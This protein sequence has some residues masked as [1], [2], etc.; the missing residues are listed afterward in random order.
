MCVCMWCFCCCLC[1]DLLS[2]YM[3]RISND[4]NCSGF[5]FL[6]VPIRFCSILLFDVIIFYNSGLSSYVADTQHKYEH[7]MKEEEHHH[8]IIIQLSIS[9]DSVICWT[10]NDKGE[11]QKQYSTI[12]KWRKSKWKIS[13]ELWRGEVC[14][15][16]AKRKITKLTCLLIKR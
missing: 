9:I 14:E 11:A 15:R 12:F 4:D 3:F 2:Y 5:L 10:T 6:E 7:R 1:H 8:L 13:K 16:S